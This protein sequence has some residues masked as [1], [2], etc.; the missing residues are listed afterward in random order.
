[1]K[2]LAKEMMDAYHNS[3]NQIFKTIIRNMRDNK[4]TDYSRQKALLEHISAI[5]KKYKLNT[6]DILE[7]ALPNLSEKAVEEAL[8][9]LPDANKHATK[10]H[11]KFNE[12][13]VKQAIEETYSSVAG[14]TDKMLLD[15]KQMIRKTVSDV[16]RVASIQG[17]TRAQVYR[18]T[19]ADILSKD[20]EFSFVD[21]AN[22]KWHTNSYLEML[23][24][25]IVQDVQR[26]SYLNTLANE[27]H[28]LVKVSS[29]NTK[30]PKCRPYEGKIL[31]VSGLDKKYDS[32][33]S[34]KANGLFHPNCK[35]RL[36][37]YFKE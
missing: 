28:D 14:M 17:K 23:S 33:E 34:A 21:N 36:I 15:S 30:C 35:H 9:Q 25:T 19:K 22:R 13:Y 6:K 24:K 4:F 31:S 8:E 27:E 5:L 2:D 1:M 16:M 3:Y 18:D 29:H 10:W 37:A 7:E 11:S 26:E 32:L 12:S 20:P